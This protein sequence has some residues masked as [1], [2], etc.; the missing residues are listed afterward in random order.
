[1][2]LTDDETRRMAEISLRLLRCKMRDR[3]HRGRLSDRFLPSRTSLYNAMS[4]VVSKIYKNVIALERAIN[5][6]RAAH[7]EAALRI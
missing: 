1:M 6:W 5:P 3:R 7:V 2:W 4:G